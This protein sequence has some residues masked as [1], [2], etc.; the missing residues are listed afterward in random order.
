MEFDTRLLHGVGTYDYPYGSTIPPI[1]QAV[2][3]HFPS[4]E[5]TAA[6]FERT[7]DGHAYTRV[8]NPTLQ[9]LEERINELEGGIGA[10]ACASGM[11]AVV[12]SVMNLVTAGDEII[13]GSGTYGG[14]IGIFEAFAKYGLTVRFV[15]NVCVDEL[16]PMIND[17]TKVIFGELVGNPSLNVVDIP[18][19]SALAHAHGIP[20]IIDAT[21][22]TPYITRPLELG[23]DIVIHSTTKYIA[24]SGQAIG[25]VIVDGGKFNWDFD[26]FGGLS[27]YRDY[28]KNAYLLRLRIDF[29]ENLGAC[30]SPM[31]AYLTVLGL[32]TL[33]LR[34]ERICSNALAL[35]R[36]LDQI[37]G[38]T[39][40]YPGLPE[41]PCYNLIH[42]ECHGY[43]GGL[44]TFRT[45][46]KESAFR[47]INNLK[48]ALKATSLGDVRTLV[49]HPKSTIYLHSTQEQCDA[50]GVYDDTVRVSVG[51]EDPGDLIE[52]F[53]EAIAQ[54][55]I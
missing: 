45:G 37:G 40:N 52:D 31:N 47:V 7:I 49:I 17:K 33:A 35:A 12:L 5:M 21:T 1:S 36:A 15:H 22:S 48:V 46:S 11:A 39:V 26:K 41:N 55:E 27:A 13:V 50:A 34:M 23:A 2:E 24:G 4:A 42:K 25:G 54:V 29:G 51:I 53:R 6:A 14:T 44:L 3:Y 9:T 8:S 43:G 28:G 19:V 20:L 30:M 10:Y 16:E 32:E 18:A 38:I